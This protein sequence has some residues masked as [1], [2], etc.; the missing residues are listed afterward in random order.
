MVTLITDE[1]IDNTKSPAEEQVANLLL[2]NSSIPWVNY[3]DMR[4]YVP[5][6]LEWF[7]VKVGSHGN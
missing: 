2:F 1:Q 3:C 5:F 7:F 4:Q 6:D